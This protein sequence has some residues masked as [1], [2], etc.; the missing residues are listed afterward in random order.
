MK[1][2]RMVF[3][4]LLALWLM[5]P[6]CS[7]EQVTQEGDIIWLT[8]KG[9]SF[10]LPEGFVLTDVVYGTRWVYENAQEGVI[11]SVDLADYGLKSEKTVIR[12]IRD[13]SNKYIV[14]ELEINGYHF[15]LYR[16]EIERNFCHALLLDGEGYSLVL[17]CTYPID[18]ELNEIPSELLQI[19][20]SFQPCEE[21]ES[22]GSLPLSLE[23]FRTRFHSSCS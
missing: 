13:K 16:S 18:T 21:G 20:Q 9:I 3:C 4:C 22:F 11:F 14:E 6:L 10:Q 5:L 8:E 17:W 1:W 23:M 12:K 15:L 7:A 19:I 2:V